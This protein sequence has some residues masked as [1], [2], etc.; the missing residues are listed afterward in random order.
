MS[1]M[2]NGIGAMGNRPPP[3]PTQM[4]EQL[5]SKL[6][7][8]GKGYLEASDIQSAIDQLST[9]DE[10]SSVASAEEVFSALDSD[11]DGKVTSTELA[12]SFRTT[13]ES[14]GLS[15]ESGGPG[16]GPGGPGGRPPP[17][18]PPSESSSTSTA[19]STD[20]TTTDSTTTSDAVMNTIMQLMRTYGSAEQSNE[21]SAL[22]SLSA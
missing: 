2:M 16:G 15:Q 19:A 4:A 17:P 11:G 1:S 22:L 12:D 8:S 20:S 3:D 9:T 14:L 7:T 18:P 6:D 10:R 5:V 13:A 21:A